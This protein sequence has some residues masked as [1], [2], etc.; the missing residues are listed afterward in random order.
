[1]AVADPARGQGMSAVSL[2]TFRRGEDGAFAEDLVLRGL[3]PMMAKRLH[4]W[5]LDSFELERLRR[6]RQPAPPW[7]SK[8]ELVRKLAP[9]LP[10]ELWSRP[11]TGF[12]LPLAEWLNGRRDPLPASERGRGS[13]RLALTVLK[14]LGIDL[15]GA[16]ATR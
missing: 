3:H 8:R 12:Y 7:G 4:L 9:E 13:R 5:R 11:K 14:E 10:E 2:H 1:V 6:G 16:R 15:D